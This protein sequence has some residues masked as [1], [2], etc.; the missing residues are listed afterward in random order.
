[1]NNGIF[2][3]F[4]V[5]TFS[6]GGITLLSLDPGSLPQFYAPRAMG[7]LSFMYAFF[8]ILPA[9][10]YRLPDGMD[11]LSLAK[12]KAALINLQTAV[13]VSLF[14]DGAG[15]LGLYELHKVG[16]PY[17]KIAHFAVTSILIIALVNFVLQ[18]YTLNITKAIVV[19]AFVVMSGGILW[20]LSEFLSDVLLGTKRFGIRGENVVSD[21]ALDLVMDA[22]GIAVASFL[23]FKRH[24]NK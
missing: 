6:L 11:K 4:S 20:E 12:K 17:D 19:S 15:G 24:N 14:F 22:L 1:M 23:V 7:T 13:A 5:L 10:I 8:I 18:W 16:I 2:V 3:K 9:L 21:T